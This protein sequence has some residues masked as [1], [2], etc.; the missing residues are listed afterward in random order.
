M[1]QLQ[2][3]SVANL[4]TLEKKC[5]NFDIYLVIFNN[6]FYFIHTIRIFYHNLTSY[7][8]VYGSKI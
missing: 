8:V 2:Y 5:Q 4:T 6:I 7:A 1:L 3:K